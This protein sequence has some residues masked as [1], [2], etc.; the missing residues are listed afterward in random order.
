MHASEVKKKKTT[1]INGLSDKR[2]IFF[3]FANSS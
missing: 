3:S 1:L 2:N